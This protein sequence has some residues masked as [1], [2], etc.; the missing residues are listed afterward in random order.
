[1]P[2]YLYSIAPNATP[3]VTTQPLNPSL[4]PD[5][6]LVGTFD[7]L[8]DI[9]GKVVGPGGRLVDADPEPDYAKQR[10]F[11]YP[12]VEDQLDAIW[13][14]MDKGVLPK[15]EPMYSAVKA[16]KDRYPKPTN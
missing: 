13:N 16:V 2:F 9:A 4:F 12:K 5:H 6:A 1:M 15:I 7:T 11:R 10:R 8:P 3:E 14:A